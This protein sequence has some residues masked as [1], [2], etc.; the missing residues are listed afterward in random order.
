VGVY[1]PFF[2]SVCKRF[3]LLGLEV[4]RKQECGSGLDCWIYVIVP[5]E[6]EEDLRHVSMD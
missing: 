2:L 1:P 6:E 4:Y 3:V 5:F